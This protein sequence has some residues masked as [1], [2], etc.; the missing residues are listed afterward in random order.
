MSAHSVRIQV[1]RRVVVPRSF[2]LRTEAVAPEPEAKVSLVPKKI[3]EAGAWPHGRLPRTHHHVGKGF[4]VPTTGPSAVAVGEW[5]LVVHHE[6]ASPVVQRLTV[7]RGAKDELRIVGG[8]KP[9]VGSKHTAATLTIVGIDHKHASERSAN[10]KQW[11][12]QVRLFARREA[13]LMTGIEHDISSLGPARRD[14]MRDR[15]LID[16]GA[17][18]TWF[19]C[20]RREK[21]TSVASRS[22]GSWIT[23]S[24]EKRQ[25][26]DRSEK[27]HYVPGVDFSILDFYA[28][29]DEVGRTHAG[30][31]VEAS[32]LSHGFLGGPILFDTNDH[33]ETFTHRD[34][35]DG[36][37]RRKDW[38]PHEDVSQRLPYLD[39]AF[40]R[41]DG[42]F[43]VWGCLHQ[44]RITRAAQQALR[45][46]DPDEMF[47]VVAGDLGDVL[48]ER[49]SR[50]YLKREMVELMKGTK[51]HRAQPNGQG[52]HVPSYPG[53]A[54]R[55]LT[56]RVF[57]APPGTGANLR[58]VNQRLSLHVDA[59]PRSEA[60]GVVAFL[61][62]EFGALAQFDE[63]GYL[64][65]SVFQQAE[66]N[67]P[68]WHT[69][70]WRFERE[71]GEPG[72]LRLP[73]G[74]TIVLVPNQAFAAPRPGTLAGRRG[75]TYLFPR[76]RIDD[77]L[78]Q[79]TTRRIILEPA[80]SELSLHVGFDGTT[81]ILV[82]DPG[83][84]TAEERKATID[85]FGTV[86]NKD[87]R[88]FVKDKRHPARRE[89]THI[90]E[91]VVPQWYW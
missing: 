76:S 37:G 6:H 55:K 85:T 72:E 84:P 71:E 12:V 8:W 29:L 58:L 7:E 31:V 40:H 70:R 26:R 44:S 48:Q 4:F 38:L 61:E 62:Q 47:T 34:P 81:T 35:N 24:S 83:S 74:T 28:H 10:S 57:A 87:L 73:S 15:E 79:G 66:L 54:S 21:T 13:V 63:D 1:F 14:I 80:P 2:G 75:H 69:D 65:H 19:D 52:E 43:R 11:V 64:D 17:L 50:A 32:I 49:T 22:K 59:S 68:G 89:T 41:E 20:R 30:S 56:A 86:W 5:L 53:V 16:D 90:L 77:V 88:K 67:D 82:R 91:R 9:H 39:A 42:T 25:G 23:M 45:V 78:E 60:H 46:A 33:S 27:E 18:V 51:V 3:A 36:D